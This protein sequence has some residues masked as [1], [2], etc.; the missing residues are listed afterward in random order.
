MTMTSKQGKGVKGMVIGVGDY[1]ESAKYG[2]V[3]VSD[4][5]DGVLDAMRAG[6]EMKTYIATD[7]RRTVYRKLLPDG[8]R[9]YAVDR[10]RSE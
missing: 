3:L 7:Q 10:A 4:V 6:Y 9:L 1:V 5:F 8:G 2:R